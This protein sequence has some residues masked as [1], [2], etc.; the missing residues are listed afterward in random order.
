[1][2]SLKDVCYEQIKDNYWYGLFGDFKIIID[3][4][5]GY[6]NATKLCKDGGR[7]FKKWLENKQSQELIK[8]I[9]EKS[10][11]RIRADDFSDIIVTITGGYG[12]KDEIIRGTYVNQDL[13]TSIA[14]WISPEFT[15]NVNKI[16]TNYF[17]NEFNQKYKNDK[18]KLKKKLDKIKIKMEKLKLENERYKEVKDD[19]TPKTRNPDK[20]HIFVLIQKNKDGSKHPYYAMRTQ[21]LSFKPHLNRLKERY[22][23]L[24][25]IQEIKYNPNSINL[26]NRV[27]E[28]LEHIHVHF[29]G[30][31]L[32]GDYTINQ[33]MKDIERLNKF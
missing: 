6:F 8:F 22:P 12:K 7:R 1:M 25:V 18:D 20:R 3:K 30:I 2:A 13:I 28:Q 19:I 21:R 24:Q 14:C 15:F 26:F 5:T 9:R 11:A 4:D 10:S 31:R 23:N 33:L 16:I 17:A 29:N 27:K 32:L